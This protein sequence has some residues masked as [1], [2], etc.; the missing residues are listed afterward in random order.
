MVL[1][2]ENKAVLALQEMKRVIF[3]K[4][5]CLYKM[6]ATVL[7]GGH[8]LM[9]DIPGVGKTTVAKTFAKVMSLD[10]K[11]VQFTPDV[12][13]SDIVGFS[14][15]KKDSQS[16]EYEPGAIMCNLFLGDEINRTSPK[17]QSALLEAMEEK[18]VTVDGHTRQLPQPFVVIATQNPVGSIGT[19]ELPESQMDR[20][21]ICT[22]IGYPSFEDE[23]RIAKGKGEG[24]SLNDIQ[25]ILSQ[26]ELLQ[27]RK[28]VEQVYI[29]DSVYE[30]ICNLV[31]ST[32]EHPQIE[33]GVSPRGTIAIVKMAR[34]IA[35]LNNRDYVV[36]SDIEEI[37]LDVASHR[38]VLKILSQGRK[39]TSR[40]VLEEILKQIKKPKTGTISKK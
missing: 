7:A 20:F 17:T 13:P 36:P 3:G 8:I 19:Q 6:M 16:F 18:K 34:A 30:Y 37:F 33:L 35:Y 31:R 25:T 32:R 12:M 38:I 10:S 40:T 11:R 26:E 14:M 9:D 2:N 15:Y 29:H 1:E 5:D 24:L 39:N 22:T 4:D 23:M 27:I 21:M 28:E